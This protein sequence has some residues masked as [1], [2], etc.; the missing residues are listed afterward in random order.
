MFRNKNEALRRIQA[1]M[2]AYPEDPAVL[3]HSMNAP[4]QRS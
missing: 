1:L 2:K 4:A 3:A